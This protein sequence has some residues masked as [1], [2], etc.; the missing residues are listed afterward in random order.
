MQRAWSGARG[1]RTAFGTI[2]MGVMFGSVALGIQILGSVLGY[3][4]RH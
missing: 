2:L 4:G 1:L 3:G